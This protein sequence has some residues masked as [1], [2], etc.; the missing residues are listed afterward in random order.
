M[1]MAVKTVRRNPMQVDTDD[2]YDDLNEGYFNF[3]SFKG[4]NSKQN[5]ISIDQE[6]FEDAKNVYLD[7]N[8]QLSTRPVVNHINVLPEDEVIIQIVKINSL[9][10]YHTFDGT[11]YYIRFYMADAWQ[12][13]QVGEKICIAWIYDKYFVFTND[14]IF[15]FS[16]NYDDNSVNW[17]KAADIIYIPTFTDDE[18]TS[19]E[20]NIFTTGEIFSY[21]FEYGVSINVDEII[22]SQVNVDIDGEVFQI[23]FQLN[24]DKV[25]TKQIYELSDATI[26]VARNRGN[27]IARTTTNLT[28]L[29]YSADGTMFQTIPFPN[30]PSERNFIYTISDDGLEIYFACN[31]NRDE[32]PIIF[33]MPLSQDFQPTSWIQINNTVQNNYKFNAN[34]YVK[35]DEDSRFAHLFD[36]DSEGVNG[37]CSF[38]GFSGTP[39]F[40]HSP[41]AG[42][43]AIYYTTF[44]RAQY[45]RDWT[46]S[47]DG[48][49]HI[50]NSNDDTTFS[51]TPVNPVPTYDNE[52]QLNGQEYSSASIIVGNRTD[53][54]WSLSTSP[55]IK[56]YP[57]YS[58]I[59]LFLYNNVGRFITMYVV[60]GGDYYLYTT[61]LDSSNIAQGSIYY[62]LGTVE[63]NS[64]EYL[65]VELG[66]EIFNIIELN[67]IRLEGINSCRLVYNNGNLQVSAAGYRSTANCDAILQ[68]VLSNIQNIANYNASDYNWT[69]TYNGEGGIEQ[70]VRLDFPWTAQSTQTYTTIYENGHS[71]E[72]VIDFDN[73]V[74][75]NLYYYYQGATIPLLDRKDEEGQSYYISPLYIDYS[76]KYIMYYSNS[77]IYSSNYTGQITVSSTEA[78][79]INY[80]IPDR[81]VNFIGATSI[82]VFSID[83]K[84]Y[85]TSSEGEAGQL[86]VPESNVVELE[87]EITNLVVF[88]Q[89]SL[90]VFLEDAVYEFMY[91]TTNSVYRLASTKLQL[92][93]KKGA[94]VLVSY[95]G[96]T[97]FLSTVKGLSGL[98]YQDFVQ[99][100]EQVYTYLTD[101]ILDMYDDYY[102]GGP[103]K[104]YQYKYWMF[105]YRQDETTLYLYDTRNSSWWK[106][107]FIH[108]I[109]QIVYTDDKVIVLMN[110]TTYVMAHNN[111]I[112][113][114]QSIPFDW[115]ILSQK[116]HFG[117]PNYYKHVR[118]LAIIT[119]QEGITMR[120]KLG[121]KNYRNLRN[122]IDTDT[123]EYSIEQLNTLIKRVSFMKTNAFQFSI[124][125]DSTDKYPM[126]F[127]VPDIAIKYRIT[128]AIR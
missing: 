119:S 3:T 44:G 111:T 13:Y 10:I 122:L 41:E 105:M 71:E 26:Y 90:G 43:F 2:Y 14:N 8:A 4:I 5:Y 85:W 22:G 35:K 16:Y 77:K 84:L 118:Q 128:E 57:G 1:V 58:S 61:Q 110:D 115:Y 102:A 94:D 54:R 40:I 108:P 103:I 104:L 7:Q 9:T 32:N 121:F 95:D 100:T 116:L 28:S 126:P 123:V 51:Y 60:S 45:Y 88:S 68:L 75:T 66:K 20:S 63:I 76:E 33:Y 25:F 96:S 97:I 47:Y 74:L 18:S 53:N 30:F 107:E 87:D 99:S 112:Y 62:G 49:N 79:L 31:H 52:G 37:C 67:D 50:Y 21:I 73:N 34:Q 109:K 98:T 27:M 29:Y 81:I 12:V 120:Y 113:D 15:A 42:S 46:H 92:G 24:N 70:G 117:A 19:Q 65:Y 59:R 80:L 82:N 38:L 93:C 69:Y 124:S 48:Y 72:F 36:A 6:S 39:R 64:T 86:Y 17:Y 127:V 78:G 91:D 106:W 23:T 125:K 55:C 56:R 83:N 89:T 101:N 11:N 114:D